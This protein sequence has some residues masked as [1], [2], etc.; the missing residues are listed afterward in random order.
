MPQKYRVFLLGILAGVLSIFMLWLII[1]TKLSGNT[2][3]VIFL[4]LA[5]LGAIVQRYALREIK[6]PGYKQVSTSI[7]FLQVV[8]NYQWFGIFFFGFMSPYM[9]S[10]IV[11]VALKNV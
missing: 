7:Y 10:L 9:A 1:F 5:I 6:D 8:R 3:L 11:Y 4:L 2:K